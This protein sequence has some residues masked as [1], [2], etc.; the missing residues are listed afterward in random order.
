MERAGTIEALAAAYTEAWN[1]ARPEAVAGS[2]AS[3]RAITINDGDPW[4][5]REGVA[6]MAAGFF[7]DV[8]DPALTCDMV[9]AANDRAV[10]A[11]TFT[12]HHA[13]SGRPL[14]IVGWEEWRLDRDGMIAYSHGWFDA[15][16]YALQCSG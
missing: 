8:P 2:F 14:R 5:G 7:A 13:G 6:A 16:D 9:R 15:A 3:D 10:Y 1:S 12:G 11:W 4:R